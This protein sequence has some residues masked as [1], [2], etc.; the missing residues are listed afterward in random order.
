MPNR[1]ADESSPYLL[2]HANNPVDWFPW[3]T[4]ALLKSRQEDKPIFLSIGYSACHWCHVM[5]HE[6]FENPQ[7]AGFLNQHFVSIKVDREERP[8][9]D[10]IYM[11]AVMA[12]QGHGGW[13]LSAFLTPDQDFFF[14]GTYWPPVSR[15]QMPGFDQVL[16]SVLDAW[17]NK[18]QDVIQQSRQITKMIQSASENG[19]LAGSLDPDLI[20]TAADTLHQRWDSTWGGFGTAPK[21]PHPMDLSLLLRLAGQVGDR[22][23]RSAPTPAQ[24]LEMVELSLQRMAMGGIHDHLAGGFARY[25]VDERWLVPHFE[26]MLYDNALLARVY[27]AAWQAT[28]KSEYAD[29]CRSTL[30]YLLNDLSDA[31]GGLYSTEDADSEGEEGKFYVWS[32]AEIEQTLE[33]PVARTF[34]ELYN[35][36]PAGNFEGHNILNL[37]QSL[38]EFAAERQLNEDQLATD[39]REARTR[40]LAVRNTRIRPGLD[41]KVITSWNA[42]GIEALVDA[43]VRLD[44]ERFSAAARS[45]ADFLLAQLRAP[46]GRL[47]HTWRG[48]EAKLA[49]YLDDYAW[50]A[51]ACLSCYRLD[52]DLQWIE[53]ASV[54]VHDMIE[55]FHDDTNGAFWYTADDHEQ[56]IAR[57]RDWQDGAVPGGNSMAAL[58]CLRLGRLSGNTRLLEIA[59]QTMIAAMPLVR[60]AP[61]AA[62]QML[63]A[64]HFL[65]HEQTQLILVTPDRNEIPD[66]VLTSLQQSTPLEGSLIVV[67]PNTSIPDFLT[68]LL[69]PRTRAAEHPTLYPCVGTRCTAPVTGWPD[70]TSYCSQ[71][72]AS[73]RAF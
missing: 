35:V 23:T 45:A 61:L 25:S 16:G 30:N 37:R 21:F 41:D 54:L 52:F 56:L 39:M 46:D 4:E 1:L 69:Q 26:K 62:S 50:L 58:A 36:T 27:L 64:M 63:I 7:I 17:Q 20:E 40:L 14:G 47:L 11:A 12:M 49:A 68:S 29:T 59:E 65:L 8:D 5:E 38:A 70:I 48:G 71:L 43:A 9:L 24:M 6:S 66:P 22:N 53:H 73:I 31:G 72:A 18:Q 51:C 34:C 19:P 13:P 55:H 42:M 60:R 44:D 57:T 2:Q 28:G 33:Q 32:V 15:A 10:Q 3:S 67:T